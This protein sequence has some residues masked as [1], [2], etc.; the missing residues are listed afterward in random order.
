MKMR[1]NGHAITR[2]K[3]ANRR[4]KPSVKRQ[5]WLDSFKVGLSLAKDVLDVV[6][7][8]SPL[9]L[10][11]PA[12]M[13]WIYLRRIGWSEI[14]GESIGSV[15]GL[16]TLLASAVL[17]LLSFL[18]MFCFPS[19]FIGFVAKFFKEE[20]ASRGRVTKLLFFWVLLS[21]FVWQV[22]FG[23]FF[24][25]ARVKDSADKSFI[26]ATFACAVVSLVFAW[27]FR[28]DLVKVKARVNVHDSGVPTRWLAKQG[29]WVRVG[30][31]LVFV[32]LFP[33]LSSFAT[34]I[35]LVAM[36]EATGLEKMTSTDGN[37]VFGLCCLAS[38]TGMVP[39]LAYLAAKIAGLARGKTMLVAL[40][41]FVVSAYPALFLTFSLGPVVSTVLRAA[42][43]YDDRP[44]VYQLLNTKLV[45]SIKAIHLPLYEVAHAGNGDDPVLFVGA[46]VR[47]NF[48]GVKLLCRDDYD[49]DAFTRDQLAAA[50]NA[51]KP[52]P[53]LVGGS[54][55]L[56]VKS[57]DVK[58]IRRAAL[59]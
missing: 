38:V 45:P 25:V 47:F 28:T 56:P 29:A 3:P 10:I 27:R 55:C 39:G 41:G 16:M 19:L 1:A 43:L 2:W 13:L 52:D 37:V 31:K 11:V 9:A 57:D 40:I 33:V 49:P 36:I 26:V 21:G 22:S 58:P 24:L 15:T 6:L 20:G 23:L 48:G 50:R 30:A 7:K 35:P 8:I 5:G 4:I 59:G 14:L 51:H 54:W 46:Y 53:R 42:G 32:S 12:L 44:H 17:L 18:L 34:A